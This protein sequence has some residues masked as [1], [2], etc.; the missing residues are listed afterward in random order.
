MILD[1]CESEL[2]DVAEVQAERIS[3]QSCCK[4]LDLLMDMKKMRFADW[5]EAANRLEAAQVTHGHHRKA[6]YGDELVI[7]KDHLVRHVPEQVRKDQGL[8][9]MFI[10]ERLNI[11]AKRAETLFGRL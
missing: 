5:N 1:F 3:F 8:H 4:I 6:C 2:A 10:V 7:P 9:D 11:R